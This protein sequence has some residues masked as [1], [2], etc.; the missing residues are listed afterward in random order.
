MLT[1]PALN[2]IQSDADLKVCCAAVYQSQWARLLLGESFHPGG[3]ALTRRIG[4]L[5]DLRPSDRILDVAS[6]QGTSAIFLAQEFGC[7]VVGVDYGPESVTQ[8][9]EAARAAGLADRVQFEQGD[10]ERLPFPD[11]SFAAVICE[12]AFCTFPNKAVAAAE[13]YRILGDNGRIA[14][15]DL[16][17]HGPL[18][19]ELES[20]IAWI[21]CIADAQPLARYEALLQAAGFHLTGAE[22]HD[23]ALAE[24]VRSVQGKLLAAELMVKLGKL[25]LPEAD[26]VQ[27]K[28]IAK[29][30]AT[31]VRQGQLGYV[32]VTAVR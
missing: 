28:Q 23:E 15:S 20:L 13:F 26:F 7:T 11:G 21:A 12:C 3:L 8:A 17:R 22:S 29:S 19:P 24:L 16:T 5:L 9:N 14:L 31:A 18:P 4:E 27:A 30:A 1:L 6:G 32:I 10:A 25:D 2:E